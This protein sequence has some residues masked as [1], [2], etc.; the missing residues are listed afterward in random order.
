MDRKIGC[1]QVLEKLSSD[2]MF[3]VEDSTGAKKVLKQYEENSNWIF[4]QRETE[5]LMS[6]KHK[7]ILPPSEV[8][9]WEGLRYAIYEYINSDNLQSYLKKKVSL[10]EKEVLDILTQIIDTYQFIKKNK[11]IHGNLKPTNILITE[12]NQITIKLTDFLLNSKKQKNSTYG[13][14]IDPEV[15]SD[16]IKPSIMSDI[17]S[18]GR[19]IKLLTESTN[20][21]N[22]T[23]SELIKDCLQ[24]DIRKRIKFDVLK[25]HQYFTSLPPVYKFFHGNF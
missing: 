24:F 25:S 13:K 21:H 3:L 5:I 23:T 20:S 16:N 15:I 1:Y 6:L 2:F 17:Y 14:F 18:I 11:L 9:M 8:F 4:N 22:T 10:T 19:I 12:D 7:S